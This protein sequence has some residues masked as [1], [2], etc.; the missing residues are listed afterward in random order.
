METQGAAK[1]DGSGKNSVSDSIYSTGLEAGPDSWPHPAPLAERI[2]LPPFPA[3]ALPPPLRA[4]AQ[5]QALALQVPIELPA[6]QALAAI[7]TCVAR[8]VAIEV[9]PGWQEPLN[10]FWIVALG[11][12]ER[13]SPV[14]RAATAPLIAHERK[15]R[16]EHQARLAELRDAAAD[17]GAAR[18]ELDQLEAAGPPRLLVDDVT[19]EALAIVMSA[20]GGRASLMSAEGGIFETIAGR[21]SNG[22]A[23]VDLILKA[24]AGDSVRIDRKLG[25]QA[26]MIDEPALTMAL[27]VQPSLLEGL[28][29]KPGFRGLGLLA[30]FLFALPHSMVGRREVNPPPV[31]A[32]V[33][34]SYAALI[35]ALLEIPEPLDTPPLLQLSPEAHTRMLEF[36]TEIEPRLGDGGDLATMTDWAGKLCGAVARIAALIHLVEHSG[37]IGNCGSQKV[38]VSALDA[39]LRIGV[40]LIRHAKAAFSLMGSDPRTQ[41]AQHVL[42]WIKR[43][44]HDHF[45]HRDA[46]QALK[47]SMSTDE[48]KAALGVLV[49]NGYL[50]RVEASL[51][52]GPGRRPEPSYLVNPACHNSH[53]PQ[54]GRQA[55]AA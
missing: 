10:T 49:D 28:A 5:A 27:A 3:D 51:R 34:A 9:R 11:S 19:P 32:G 29:D 37:N 16:D 42:D 43:E 2:E 1:E 45:E 20:N 24:H 30:R 14:V 41:R 44:G 18:A 39:A 21:Y 17:D 26:I 50:R 7:S 23:N 8:R 12:G 36:Q 46:Q 25:K 13:K 55:A 33:A 52:P 6:F 4:W 40:Y 47:G 54:K 35:A 22:V 31:P 15:L 53:N 48:L 38:S